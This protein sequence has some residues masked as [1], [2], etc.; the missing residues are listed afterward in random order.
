MNGQGDE[1]E[2]GEDHADVAGQVVVVG[3]HPTEVGVG[4]LAEH[5]ARTST[6]TTGNPISP[7][8]TIGSRAIRRS[9]VPVRRRTVRAAEVDGASG[10]G[11]WQR[12]R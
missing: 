5:P 12:R 7:T 11:R 9:S 6:V 10:P 3:R 2:G 4:A 8:A 1:A